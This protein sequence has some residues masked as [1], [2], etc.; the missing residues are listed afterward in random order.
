[1]SICYKAE[2]NECW[3]LPP[4]N[5]HH[6]QSVD[7]IDKLPGEHFSPPQKLGEQPLTLL[8]L[9][10][11]PKQ[12]GQSRL[13]YRQPEVKLP[14]ISGAA[15]GGKGGK[16]PPMGV[17]KDRWTANLLK[18]YP[19]LKFGRIPP[20]LRSGTSSLRSGTSFGRSG[21]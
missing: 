2:T 12:Y 7:H 11:R 21:T 5:N 13:A 20:D 4:V 19:V 16:L 18:S 9:F 10:R 14:K 6:R 8:P 3:R 1:M 17:R 15:R